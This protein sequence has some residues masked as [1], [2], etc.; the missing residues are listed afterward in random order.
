MKTFTLIAALVFTAV[1]YGAD[2]APT[3]PPKPAA[4]AKPP[5]AAK[6]DETID[7]FDGTS[8]KGWKIADF[9][10]HGEI[11]VV[12]LKKVIESFP[13]KPESAEERKKLGNPD[14]PVISIESGAVLGGINYTNPTPKIDYEIVLET[15]RVDG[16]DFFCGLTF[17]VNDTFCS[18]IVGGWG[19]GLVGISSLDGLDASENETTK[20]MAVQSGR[21]Y[22]IRVRVTRAKLEAWI[23]QEKMV[24]VKLEGKRVSLRP[25]EIEI[26]KPFGYATYQT[27]AAIRL[28]QIQPLSTAK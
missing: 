5:A 23:D 21:W 19:G 10:G 12:P 17:P 2:P 26:S 16:S 15:M 14:T 27:S 8:L 18:L 25:G 9:A 20:F 28:F 13:S 7:L 24:D 6:P 3:T 22:K 1:S 4:D 11:K